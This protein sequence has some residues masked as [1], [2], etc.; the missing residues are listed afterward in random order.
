M[1]TP[2]DKKISKLTELINRLLVYLPSSSWY[3]NLIT[4]NPG[5]SSLQIFHFFF[6]LKL[7]FFLLKNPFTQV[8]TDIEMFFF[9]NYQILKKNLNQ[10][11]FQLDTNS[12]IRQFPLV[13][14]SQC[15]FIP[16]FKKKL[17]SFIFFHKIM[18]KKLKVDFPVQRSIQKT[19][20]QVR[21]NPCPS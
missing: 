2:I 9:L 7:Y 11:L 18:L 21:N 8:I 19:S 12:S 16:I 10:V 1:K 6:F 14:L 17:S 13:L 4:K 15:H 20:S 3:K 5:I